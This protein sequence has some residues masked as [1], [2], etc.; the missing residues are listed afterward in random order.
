MKC[1][2]CGADLAD[3]ALFCRDCGTKLPPP[4]SRCKYCGA[5]LK[6]GEKYC[7]NCGQRIEPPVI[8]RAVSEGTRQATTGDAVR[9]NV[10]G[11][12]QVG[13]QSR[14]TQSNGKNTQFAQ[15]WNK[16]DLFFKCIAIFGAVLFLVILGAAFAH[17]TAAMIIALLQLC[18][19]VVVALMHKEYIVVKY[20]WLKYLIAVGCLLLSALLI[21]SFSWG[22]STNQKESSSV[23]QIATPTPKK[24]ASTTLVATAQPVKTTRP[25][26]KPSST[27]TPRPTQKSSSAPR[28]TAKPTPVPSPTAVPTAVPGDIVFAIDVDFEQNLL[29]SKYNVDLYLDDHYIDTLI[30][31]KH[32]VSLHKIS[33]GQ[34]TISFKE[35]G[36]SNSG[37]T[38]FSIEKDS[39]FTCHIRST[40]SGIEIFS[41]HVY[42]T[43]EGIMVKMPN[44]VGLLY[45]EALAKLKQCG[46]SNISY[47][48]VG[49]HVIWDDDNWLV[50]EQNIAVETEVL[51]NEDIE[52][53]CISLDDYFK[54]TYIG[55][56][57]ND[58]Q[59]LANA[60]GFSIRFEDSSGSNMDSEL[61]S[62][63]KKAKA[64]WVATDARQYGG[65]ART[66]VVTITFTGTPTPTPTTTKP[67][68][69]ADSQGWTIDDSPYSTSEMPVMKGTNLNTIV[70]KAA[71]LGVSKQISDENFKYGTF[72]SF[73]TAEEQKRFI[74][75]V[76]PV[77]CP[78]ADSQTVKDWVVSNVGRE[79]DTYING[80]DYRLFLGPTGN[81]CYSAGE[82]SWSS[83]KLQY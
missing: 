63:A 66:A 29:F 79:A 42:E 48:T 36:G 43:I 31:G 6:A 80:F 58:I 4:N 35:V 51:K 37:S 3:D 14:P 81:L 33:A 54:E 28:P 11:D 67:V 38:Y 68:P 15:I 20:N 61:K 22:T 57:V 74:T 62:M 60:A 26:K 12:T 44:T 72:N 24:K 19:L 75:S 45:S 39:S 23:S 32:Y 82:D 40:S 10:P 71:S 7:T 49:N 52:L 1:P 78:S 50:Q 64:R 5:E 13:N 2:N 41:N 25:T 65:V 76:A 8:T 21:L 69:T 55:K 9:Q 73:A 27:S 59:K 16:M 70:E 46:F 47:E 18:G 34:H 17:K 56:N 30:H 83:W 77:C 53:K